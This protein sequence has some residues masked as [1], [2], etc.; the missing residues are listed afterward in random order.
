MKRMNSLEANQVSGG[1]YYS[2]TSY[3]AAGV[4]FNCNHGCSGSYYKKA[5]DVRS[6]G[7]GYVITHYCI[8][9]P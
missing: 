2:G 1:V 5:H 7:K 3:Q 4:W 9:A 6:S 8:S